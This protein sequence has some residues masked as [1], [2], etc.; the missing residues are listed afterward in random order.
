M[1]CRHHVRHVLSLYHCAHGSSVPAAGAAT[2]S[3]CTRLGRLPACCTART[4]MIARE[5]RLRVRH[6]L[7]GIVDGHLPRD[8]ANAC[9]A[10]PV[11]IFKS[12]G[13]LRDGVAEAP[14]EWV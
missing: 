1:R 6:V 5:R 9:I 14:C 2:C 10:V 3:K 8:A 4:L 7:L 12:V 11:C 13:E